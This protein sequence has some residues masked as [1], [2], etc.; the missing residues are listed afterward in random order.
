MKWKGNKEIPIASHS[1]EWIQARN[2]DGDCSLYLLAVCTMAHWRPA[3]LFASH[4][5]ISALM[6][7]AEGRAHR[8]GLNELGSAKWLRELSR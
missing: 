1:S 3:A 2:V 8:T 5:L 4:P 7:R 6:V